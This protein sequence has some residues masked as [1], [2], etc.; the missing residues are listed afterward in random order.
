M[1]DL[2]VEEAY[3]LFC[4]KISDLFP[5]W[6]TLFVKRLINSLDLRIPAVFCGN[7][8]ELSAKGQHD[9][10]AEAYYTAAI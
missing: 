6:K 3:Q 8:I 5:V 10:I 2:G 4:F 7:G 1:V 9:L